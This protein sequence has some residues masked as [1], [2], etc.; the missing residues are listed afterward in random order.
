MGGCK[1]LGPLKVSPSYAPQLSGASTLHFSPPPEF[2]RAHH[3]EWLRLM[4]GRSQAFVSFSS[5]LRAQEFTFEAGIADDSGILVYWRGRKHSISQKRVLSTSG[6][7]KM[8]LPILHFIYQFSEKLQSGCKSH[9]FYL[10]KQLFSAYQDPYDVR[11]L[12][13]WNELNDFNQFSGLILF[14]IPL[15]NSDC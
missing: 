5:A 4:A 11:A 3:R 9:T 6:R 1:S 8:R 13:W 15:S 2:P 14:L 10:I 12:L 7:F